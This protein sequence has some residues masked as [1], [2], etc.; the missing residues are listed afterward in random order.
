MKHQ[1]GFGTVELIITI[2]I[3]AII[4]WLAYTNM[5]NRPTGE[6][7]QEAVDRA[8]DNVD[9]ANEASNKAQDAINSAQDVIN[10]FNQ[11]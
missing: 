9:K 6:S 10:N 11:E 4:G 5:T 7:T 8:K 1:K 3:A 2:A